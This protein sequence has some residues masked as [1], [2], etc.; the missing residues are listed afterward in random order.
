MNSFSETLF[1]DLAAIRDGK[2]LIHNITNFVVM[3]QTANVLLA[4]G[5]SPV[6]AHAAEEVEDM[7]AFAGALVL[8]MGTL[9]PELVDSMVLAGKKANQLGVPVIFDPVGAGATALRTDAARR[10]MG[11]V[12]ISVLRANASEAMITGGVQAQIRGV[13]SVEDGESI[14]DIA[15]TI[16]VEHR[17]VVAVT[18]ATDVITDGA[19]TLLCRNGDPMM[20]RV[21]GT[22]CSSTSVVAAFCAV[23]KDYWRAASEALTYYAL[24]GQI[25][26]QNAPGPGSF[27]MAL[28]DKLY[29]ITPREAQPLLAVAT[30]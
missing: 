9:W 4:V 2:P 15:R 21:T 25:A 30:I 11:E 28:R 1:A 20:G 8:N 26:A 27:E 22:G 6:M 24:C 14:G 19:R 16:A 13:D 7:V 10:I 17:M 18:G 23:Q 5:A 3:N 12:K 29:N